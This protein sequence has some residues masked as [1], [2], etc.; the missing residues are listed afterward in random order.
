M[1]K[2]IEEIC[3]KVAKKMSE[4]KFVIDICSKKENLFLNKKLLPWDPLSLDYGCSG[5]IVFFTEIDSSYPNQGWDEVCKKYALILLE[6][7]KNKGYPHFSLFSGLTGI[8]YGVH[9]AAKRNKIFEKI[10]S[11]FN[12]LFLEELNKYI[13]LPAETG[14]IKNRLPFLCS[15]GSGLSCFLSYLLNFKNN[16]E[17]KIAINKILKYLVELTKDIK[18]GSINIPGWYLSNKSLE[19]DTQFQKNIWTPHLEKYPSGFFETGMMHGIAGGLSV[20]SKALLLGFEIEGQRLA[21]K[22]IVKWLKETKQD[23]ANIQNSWP[24]RIVFNEKNPKRL[25]VAKDNYLDAWSVGAPGILNSLMLASKSLDDNDLKEYSLKDLTKVLERIQNFNTLYG[26]PFCYGWAGILSIM[27]QTALVTKEGYF[28][29]AAK[30]CA[31]NIIERYDEN[32]PFGFK[33]SPPTDDENENIEIDNP[34]L[35]T[36]TSGILLSLLFYKLNKA[37]PWMSIFNLD[38]L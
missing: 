32:L 33:S 6:V 31:E 3:L 2:K 23:F 27:H 35:L 37:K 18:L 7:F 38:L 12:K 4:P 28:I 30:T 8:C 22:K 24:K 19:N 29:N 26:L 17:S 5:L 36:G 34:G 1:F 10:D 15:L 25:E 16:P 11:S 21:I 9:I 13:L 14:K 20:L